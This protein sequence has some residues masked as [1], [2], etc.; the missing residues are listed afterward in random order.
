MLFH[1]FELM[2]H[3]KSS[4]LFILLRNEEVVAGC[5]Q[6]ATTWVNQLSLLEQ[7]DQNEILKP[8]KNNQKSFI[9]IKP[10]FIHIHKNN[11]ERFHLLK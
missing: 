2:N 8:V 10:L 1:N 3:M 9:H 7:D 4:S 5:Q 6:M 11:S